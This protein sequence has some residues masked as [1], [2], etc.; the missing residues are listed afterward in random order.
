MYECEDGMYR[1]FFL[2]GS[3]FFLVLGRLYDGWMDGWI[4]GRK[5]KRIEEKKEKG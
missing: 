5:K 1:A 2:M 3:V 4:E